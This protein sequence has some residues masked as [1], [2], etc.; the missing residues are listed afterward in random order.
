MHG[1]VLFPVRVDQTACC[2]AEEAVVRYVPSG[3]VVRR[4]HFSHPKLHL[5]LAL[6]YVLKEY[7]FNYF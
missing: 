6:A 5:C 7:D 3:L 2:C 1:N 4:G